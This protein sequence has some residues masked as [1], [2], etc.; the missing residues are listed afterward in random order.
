MLCKYG[1]CTRLLKIK[2]KLKIG[3][4]YKVGR[5]SRFF[6]GVLNKTIIPLA[7]VGY[8]MIIVRNLQYGPKIRN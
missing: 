5:N 6:V 8:D 4:F 1:N 7:L 3:C 2:N